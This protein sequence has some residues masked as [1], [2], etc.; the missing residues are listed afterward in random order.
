MNLAII[1]QR[2]DP[3]GGAEQFVSRAAAALEGK[4]T[5]VSVI[6]RQWVGDRERTRWIQCDPFYL[7]RIWRDRSFANA[8]CTV[9]EQGQFDLVQSHE[10]IPCCDIY[11]AGDGVHAQWLQ[12]RAASLGPI[13]RLALRLS[14]FHHHLLGMERRLFQSTRLRA[15]ICNS[16]MVREEITR[17]FPD[18]AN[19]LHVIYNGVDSERFSIDTARAHRYPMRERLGIPSAA[20]VALFV[21]SGFER[22]GVGVLLEALLHPGTEDVFLVVVGNDRHAERYAS[23]AKAMGLAE[24]VKWAGP[25]DD[26]IPWYGMADVFVLPTQYDPF[27]NAALEALACGLPV[28]T[29]KRCGT[30]EI[31]RDA[32]NGFV[33]QD[34]N[35]PHEL[36]A[37]LRQALDLS[38][39]MAS[40]ARTTAENLSL[41]NMAQALMDLYARLLATPQT[42]NAK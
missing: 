19:K 40:N 41:S 28:V 26:V 7:G 4:G 17:W 31:L 3:Q 32:W 34:N 27:P 24:R 10:R 15:V 1:R 11:R 5:K 13:R 21:G 12:Y 25:Q 22:K 38:A 6:S 29:T 18:A 14:P 20:Q 35:N 16:K 42:L 2:Y 36:A 9:Q 39:S 30:A 33:C 8:V 23:Y 37:L